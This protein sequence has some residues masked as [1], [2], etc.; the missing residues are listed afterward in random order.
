[1]KAWT[2]FILFLPLAAAGGLQA[3]ELTDL[4]TGKPEERQ[5]PAEKVITTRASTQSDRD[6]R[7]R[8]QQ[9]FSESM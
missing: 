6:I 4:L 9:I 2:M 3:D 7:R 8:L 1:M 5:A